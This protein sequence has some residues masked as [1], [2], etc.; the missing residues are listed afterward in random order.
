MFIPTSN[1][2]PVEIASVMVKCHA[3]S[4]MIASLVT[5]TEYLAFD[6]CKNY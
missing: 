6:R 3:T 2:I 5:H 1:P 4:V